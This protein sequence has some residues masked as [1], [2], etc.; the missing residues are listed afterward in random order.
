MRFS[1]ALLS[2]LL[3]LSSSVTEQQNVNAFSSP[4]R[5]YLRCI[6][7]RAAHSDISNNVGR[8]G[9]I[10]GK[11]QIKIT[12]VLSRLYLSPEADDCGCDTTTTR[13][14]TIFS[15]NPSNT[16]KSLNIQ[17]AIRNGSIFNLNGEEVT[18]N[19]LLGRNNDNNLSIVIF[20]R[21]LG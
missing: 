16:A 1:T 18:M 2:I 13:T 4:L 3:V 8:G 6:S 21:S 20:L 12:S 5:R 19:G 17:Q 7:C 11:N 9:L 15:G 10:G 14:P